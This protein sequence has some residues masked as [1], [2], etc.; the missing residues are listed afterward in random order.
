MPRI[1]VI[2]DEQMVCETLAKILERGGYESACVDRAEVGIRMFHEEPFDLVI[3]DIFLPDM[4]GLEVVRALHSKFPE[5]PIIAMSGGGEVLHEDFLP[6]ARK[7]GASHVMYKP[8]NAMDL[9][10][11]VSMVLEDKCARHSAA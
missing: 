5:T 4:D 10:G 8:F 1:L 7:I 11:T 6:M 9:L 3:T 2:D